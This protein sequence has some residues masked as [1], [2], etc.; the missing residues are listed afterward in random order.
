MKVLFIASLNNPS[1]SGRQRLWAM[2]ACKA[3][4]TILNKDA[5]AK[6]KYLGAL[7]HKLK[8]GFLLRNKALESAIYKAVLQDMPDIIWIEWAREISSILLQKLRVI[9]SSVKLL[10]FMDDN[11][12]GKRVGDAWMWHYYLK[13]IP[14]FDIHLV[15][16]NSDIHNIQKL[17]GKACYLWEHGIY[18]PLFTPDDKT[19]IQYT[20]SFVG[21]CMDDRDALIGYLLDN[22]IDIH[23]FG[24][25]WEQRSDLPKKYPN[26]FHGPVEGVPY[27]AVIRQSLICLGLVSHSNED[28]WTM[29]T[30]EV[31]GCAKL[32]L[33]ENT[34]MHRAIFDG[35]VDKVLFSTKEECLEKIM[36]LV[37]NKGECAS[38]S[39]DIYQAFVIKER[40][41]A[42]CMLN[43]FKN[44]NFIF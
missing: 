39:Q 11:P 34:P 24:S 25:R 1:A 38:I 43:F 29:R 26:N 7:I 41:L 32:L 8:I 20:V 4:V 12:W 31:P 30:Y 22:G 9:N 44:N 28:E 21:T 23:V 40:T 17:G 42:V 13:N 37:A 16:R 36:Y 15:K 19:D 5:F 33:A 35:Y 3:S 18:S 6:P 2:E 14:F 10:S 27:V